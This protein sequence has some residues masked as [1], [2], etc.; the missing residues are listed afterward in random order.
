MTERILRYAVEALIGIAVAGLVLLVL[1]AT[2]ETVP[3]VYQGY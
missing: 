2:V 3:F 1:A